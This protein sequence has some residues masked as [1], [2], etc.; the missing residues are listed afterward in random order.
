MAQILGI[1][2]ADFGALASA[3]NAA[4]S[5]GDHETAR[6]LDVMARKANASLSNTKYAAIAIWAPKPRAIRWGEVPSTLVDPVPGCAVGGA[7]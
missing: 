5:R 4:M 3:A 1:S 2:E 6:R 7:K